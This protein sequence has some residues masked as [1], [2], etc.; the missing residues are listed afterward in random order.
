MK[1]LIAVL[2]AALLAGCAHDGIVT[3]PV[4]V[5]IT[6]D[7]SM[8]QCTT[9]RKS[10]IPNVDKLS[11]KQLAALLA[12]YDERLNIC[13]NSQEAVREFIKEAKERIE[14]DNQ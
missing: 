2:A 5:V 6:P 4:S 9:V 1:K 10:E 7:E 12:L 14:Q 8:Y 3:R 13:Y 11:D